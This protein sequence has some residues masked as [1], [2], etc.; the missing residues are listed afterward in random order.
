L[1]DGKTGRTGYITS[2]RLIA[3]RGSRGTQCVPANI[4]DQQNSG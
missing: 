3:G 4:G 2:L 1:I